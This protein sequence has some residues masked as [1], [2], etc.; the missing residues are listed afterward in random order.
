MKLSANEY[1]QVTSRCRIQS[2]FRPPIQGR[3][4]QQW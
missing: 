1:T 3:E 4:T 2:V